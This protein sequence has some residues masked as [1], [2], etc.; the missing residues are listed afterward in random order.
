[1]FQN[2]EPDASLPLNIF[3]GGPSDATGEMFIHYLCLFSS[4]GYND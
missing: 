4:K 2:D 1:M 3:E